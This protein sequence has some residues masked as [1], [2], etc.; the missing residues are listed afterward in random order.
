MVQRLAARLRG[1]DRD[2][3]LLL[4]RRLADEVLQPARAQRAVEL[5][6]VDQVLGGLDARRGAHDLRAGAQGVGDERLGRVVGCVAQQLVGLDDAEAELD[7][8][9]AR[10]PA[11]VVAARDHDLLRAAPTAADLLAQ[12]DDDPLGRALAD[13]R[14]GLQPRDVAGGER[15]DQLARRA[16][17]EHRERDLRADGLH[18]DQREEQIAL[19]LGREAEERERVVAHDEMAVQ[20]DRLADRRDLAQRLGRDRQPVADP[21]GQDDDVVGA[22][23]GDLAAD[24]CDHACLR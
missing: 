17:A 22:A 10:Q 2:R 6:L 20:R 7:E 4:E 8:P 5:V 12:L 13:P 14:H 3:E 16:A 18:A 9:V 11:R 1:L 19:L 15:L 23:D 24:E 21:A